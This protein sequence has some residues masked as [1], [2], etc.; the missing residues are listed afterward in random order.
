MKLATYVENKPKKNKF[1]LRLNNN[2]LISPP[3]NRSNV[4]LHMKIF[5]NN[6]N[7]DYIPNTTRTDGSNFKFL[8][9][10]NDFSYNINKNETWSESGTLT[11]NE[12]SKTRT[13]VNFENNE[14]LSKNNTPRK[15]LFE[16][17]TQ[18]QNEIRKFTNITNTNKTIKITENKNSSKLEISK[19]SQE[20]LKLS[21]KYIKTFK[22]EKL[23]S[24]FKFLILK[25]I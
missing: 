24:N 10:R 15:T 22:I 23:S 1:V 12:R 7:S 18:T 20:A 3:S 5:E 8:T 13:G 17:S 11:A 21:Q 9:P 19:A 25:K 6:N 14:Y 2:T 16:H 4:N